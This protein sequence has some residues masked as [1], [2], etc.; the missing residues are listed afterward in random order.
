M[1]NAYDEY[2][3]CFVDDNDYDLTRIEDYK[4]V[5]SGDEN[6]II[7]F[8]MRECGLTQIEASNVFDAMYRRDI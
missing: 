2:E 5:C 7:T 8:L 4:L 3:L 6:K 1:F